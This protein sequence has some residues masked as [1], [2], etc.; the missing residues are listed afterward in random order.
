VDNKEPHIEAQ[1]KSTTGGEATATLKAPTPE[2]I[3]EAARYFSERLIGQPEVVQ[4]LTNVLYRQTALLK[5]LLEHPDQPGVIPRDPTVLLFA[6]GSWGKTLAA[7][8][9]PQA[10]SPLGFAPFAILTPLP[11][12]LEGNLD[13]DAEM[14]S[15]PFA[16][17]L[18]ERL[19]VADEV[20]SRFVVNL[21]RLLDAGMFPMMDPE[22]KE[23]HPLPLG[24]TTFIF[25]TSVGEEEILHALHPDG[26]LGFLRGASVSPEQAYAEV[27]RIIRKELATLPEPILRHVDETVIFRPL[28]NGDLRRIFEAEIEFYEHSAF[29]GKRLCLEIEEAAQDLLFAEALEGLDVYG[30]RSLNRTLQR[31]V[32]PVVYRAYVEGKLAEEDLE[33]KAIRVGLRDGAVQ[34]EIAEMRKV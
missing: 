3:E 22:T 23:V 28:S 1:D 11:Q 20:N 14:F 5:R 9:I 21:A 15:V 7:K 19:E 29:P 31:Y 25:T 17:V 24:L 34:V 13:L 12:D 6:G 2:Q 30:I 8:L 33:S 32:D 10:L 18:V 27:Q 16:V 26:K 4:A